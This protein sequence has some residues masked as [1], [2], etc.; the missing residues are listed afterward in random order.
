MKR[1]QKNIPSYRL[2]KASGRAFVE[3]NGH[4]HYLGPYDN[5]A[6][7]QAYHRLIN[8]WLDHDRQLPIASDQI[9]V[10]QMVQRFWQHA[11]IHYRRPDG[12]L[13]SEPD[14]YR[15][16]IRPLVQ[17]YGEIPACQFG[18]RSLRA[19]RHR[20]VEMGWCRTNINKQVN[21][22]PRPVTGRK[23]SVK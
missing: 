2:H 22:G 3:L 10:V 18:P 21:L 11:K 20:M 23:S 17:L 6:T 5:D 12:S 15:Q 8:E 19:V 13:T 16:A 9:T 4:R 7:R 1:K 14:N